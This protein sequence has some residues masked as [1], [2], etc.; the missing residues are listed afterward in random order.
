MAKVSYANLKL[1]SNTAVKTFEFEGQVIEVKQYLSIE[2]KYDL[3]M[4]ALQKSKEG[5]IYNALK[6]D[7]Y[8]HLNL[9]YLYT[10][11]SFTD[12]Q[13]E[14]EYKIYDALVSSGLLDLIIENID[15]DEYTELFIY[16]T[17]I[18]DDLVMTN[19]S[20]S[21]LVQ[22]FINDLPANAQAAASIVDSFDKEK[23]Q[24]VINFAKAANGGR[25]IT[26]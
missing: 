25:D 20:T 13:K 22:S 6:L 16:L 21:A 8:F 5:N 19:H 10:N 24:E 9:V 12:K 2:D 7:V 4:I 3:I 23:Y 18:E 1:K 26:E 15:E 17:E 14:N 11:L